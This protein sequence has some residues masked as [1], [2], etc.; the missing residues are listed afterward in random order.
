MARENWINKYY[1]RITDGSETVGKWVLNAYTYLVNGIEQKLFFFDQ[2]KAN[3]AIEWIEEHCF[4]V[5]GALA[6]GKLKLELW[7]KAFLSAIFGIVDASGKR[8]FW[9]VIL[10]IGRKNGKSLLASAI[11]DYMWRVEGGYGSEVYCVAPKLDQADIVYNTTW[12]M[13]LLDPEYQALREYCDERDAHNTKIHDDAMLPKKRRSDLSIVG[14][15]S[16]MK[17]VAFQAKTADGFNP[18]LCIC[19]EAAAWPGDR[20]LKMYEVMKSGMGTRAGEALLLTVTTS[21][22]ENDGIYD[23]LIKRSTRFLLGDSRET[24]LFPVLYMIDDV[25]KWNDI[26]ELQKSL[27]MLSKSIPVDYILSEIAVAEGSLSKRSEFICKYACIKQNSSQA[28]LNSQDVSK[29]TGEAL[30]LEDFRSTYCVGGIDLSRAVDLTA[31]CVIIEKNEKLYVFAKFF[32][33]REKVDEATAR[34][35]LPYRAFIQRGILQES[36][37]NFVDYHDCFDWFRMLV[38]QYEIL[39]LQVGYDRY[40]AQYLVQEMEQYGFRMDD[41]YQGEN[42]SPVIDEMEGLIKDGKIFIGDNDLLKIHLMDSALKQ[43]SDTMRKRLVKVSAG[44]HIDGTAALL[45]GLTVRQKW[46]NEIGSRLINT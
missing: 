16:I 12:Q 26:N 14:T 24:H 18:S 39:P 36:G 37:D 6:P 8:Q 32:M 46:F 28:W 21:G 35:G 7:Q 38:E 23:E 45:D 19:D 27:P 13:V 41:V 22:Y 3:A 29:C 15:N 5:K 25:E 30:Q 20:G 40:S 4:H 33:P 17:K 31:C 2:K 1:Q 34:D 42:L 43:N 10:V 9:E 44:V 11:A